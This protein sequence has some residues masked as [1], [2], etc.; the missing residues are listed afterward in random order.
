MFCGS[1]ICG[2][3]RTV[4]F[5]PRGK[6]SKGALMPLEP[7]QFFGE[8]DADDGVGKKGVSARQL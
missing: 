6:Y 4:F 7:T 2:I 1:V 8:K 3:V 5:R